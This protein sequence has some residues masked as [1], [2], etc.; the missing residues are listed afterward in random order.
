VL[1]PINIYDNVNIMNTKVD[2]INGKLAAETLNIFITFPHF[3][4]I[5]T[6]RSRSEACE[7]CETEIK[8]ISFIT[9]TDC[10]L[11]GSDTSEWSSFVSDELIG[12]CRPPRVL[13]LT[14]PTESI[15]HPRDIDEAHEIYHRPSQLR[16]AASCQNFISQSSRR[17]MDG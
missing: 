10:R 16:L 6:R 14:W 12:F 11:I 4:C 9:R 8:E 1:A 2:I 15:S 7:T 13:S 5:Y 17:L 3:I